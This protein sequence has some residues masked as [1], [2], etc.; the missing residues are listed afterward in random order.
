MKTLK[1]VSFAEIKREKAA[2]FLSAFAEAELAAFSFL[3]MQQDVKCLVALR[4]PEIAVSS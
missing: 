3:A 2:S 4:S 1:D